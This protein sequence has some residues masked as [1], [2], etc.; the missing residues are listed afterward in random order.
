MSLYSNIGAMVS[1]AI[2]TVKKTP[3]W[4]TALKGVG[5]LASTYAESVSKKATTSTPSY[6]PATPSFVQKKDNTILFV[7]IGVVASVVVAFLMGSK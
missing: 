2:P 6:S 7:G 3:W 5:D 4:E 1:N